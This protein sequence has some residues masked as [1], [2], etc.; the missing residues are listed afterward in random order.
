M[1]LINFI[2]E[3]GLISDSVLAE[4]SNNNVVKKFTFFQELYANGKKYG[5]AEEDLLK[6]AV[7]AG[8]PGYELLES[9]RDLST[10]HEDYN[11]LGGVERCLDLKCMLVRRKRKALC[12][13]TQRP[14]DP[15]LIVVLNKAFGA[16]SYSVGICGM[17]LWKAIYQSDVEPLFIEAKAQTLSTKTTGSR[18]TEDKQIESEARSIYKHILQ[19]GVTSGASDI[20]LIPRVGRCDVLYR[21]D[22]TN[23]KR[24]SVPNDIAGRVANLLTIDG[25]VPNKGPDTPQDGKIKYHPEGA[26]ENETRDLRF[27]ILPATYGKD[28]NIRFLNNKLYTFAELGMSPDNVATY[29]HILDMPQGLIMQVG[30]TRLYLS[31]APSSPRSTM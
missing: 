5:V 18:R 29:S 23:Y 21:I 12:V 17:F 30:P 7:S 3:R 1:D 27:S 25:K 2:K 9:T 20:H 26:P 24:M 15:G 22:G 10:E 11:K 19:L 13:V 8:G 31:S 16:G 6:W 14:D 28:L 4:I